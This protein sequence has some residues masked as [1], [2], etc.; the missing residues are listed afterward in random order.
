MDNVSRIFLAEDNPADVFLIREALQE[1]GIAHELTIFED[2]ERA[3]QFIDA[4][5]RDSEFMAPALAILDL[6]LP[7]MGGETVLSR[8][9]NSPKLRDVPVLVLT[10]SASPRDRKQAEELG[11]TQYLRKPSD[12]FEFMEVG[13]AIKKLL[14]SG[15]GARA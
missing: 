9:R 6:N 1:H 13:A 14:Q 12:L 8:I 2:G 7:R 15:T 5:E 10:T 11:A 3:L 4:A